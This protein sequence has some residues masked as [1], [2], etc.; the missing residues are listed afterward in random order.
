MHPYAEAPDMTH[1]IQLARPLT[2][3]IQEAM[4]NE[5]PMNMGRL[6]LPSV[7][8]QVERDEAPGEATAQARAGDELGVIHADVLQENDDVGRDEGVSL[9][10]LQE[11]RADGDETA[12][13]V[14]APEA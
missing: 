5:P 1:G 3:H 13:E 12:V 7:V 14:R 2:I 9:R 4:K 6:P 11:L 8:R 10:L